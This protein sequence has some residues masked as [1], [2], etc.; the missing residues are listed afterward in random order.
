M[1]PRRAVLLGV[2]AALLCRPGLAETEPVQRIGGLAFG[3]AWRATLPPEADANAARRA[4]ETIVAEVDA[5]M[6]PYRPNSD[7]GRFNR[8]PGTDWMAASH[9]TCWVVEAALSLAAL[10]DG[11]FDPTVGPL[12][13]RYGFGPIAGDRPDLSA[14]ALRPGALRKSAPGLTIDLCGIAKGRAL[15]RAARALRRLGI[16][17]ALLE[18]GGEVR[19]LGRHPDGRPWQVGIE[20]PDG[21]GAIH[22][23]ANPGSRALATSGHLPNG[24]SGRGRLS[25]IIDP[26]S[27]RPAG[28]SLASVTV[29][30]ADGMRADALATALLVLGE[31]A[32]A[33]FAERNGIDALLL[34]TD[35]SALREIATGRF[36]E[37]IIA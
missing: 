35:R 36:A 5:T 27:G 7:S 4:I 29:L 15:D 19:A 16:P 21:T 33:D 25:H 12:V 26:R 20:R 1:P 6:S 28:Q 31:K 17:D 11:A 22:R 30:D 18:I 3:S 14:I 24:Y 23:V 9:E 10:T 2:A 37:H 13:A 34:A 32:G 8:T